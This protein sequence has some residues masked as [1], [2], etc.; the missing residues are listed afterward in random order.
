MSPSPPRE[1]GGGPVSVFG[2]KSSSGFESY[3]SQVPI[4]GPLD[5]IK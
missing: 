3:R 4:V 5:I 2:G 1:N